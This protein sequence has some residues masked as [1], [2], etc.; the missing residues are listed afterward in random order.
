MSLRRSSTCPV[1]FLISMFAAHFKIDVSPH[2]QSHHAQ[3]GRWRRGRRGCLAFLT[4]CVLKSVNGGHGGARYRLA[5]SV[6]SRAGPSRDTPAVG[7][8]HHRRH[9]ERET[10]PDGRPS[11]PPHHKV[12]IRDSE[13]DMSR[14]S[15]NEFTGVRLKSARIYQIERQRSP[16][17]IFGCCLCN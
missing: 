10:S 7:R 14:L 3:F 15:C 16:V 13:K 2:F 17:S 8:C 11:P 6:G 1:L 4:G 5:S 9:R 12:V